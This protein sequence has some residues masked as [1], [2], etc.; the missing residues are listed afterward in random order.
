MELRKNRGKFQQL[1]TMEE[2]IQAAKKKNGTESVGLIPSSEHSIPNIR[3][4][5]EREVRVCDTRE[6]PNNAREWSN[7]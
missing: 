2:E 7:R 4:N 6:K 3:G 1:A 5:W